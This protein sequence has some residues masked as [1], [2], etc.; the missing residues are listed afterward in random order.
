MRAKLPIIALTVFLGC[1]HLGLASPL[2]AARIDVVVD[3]GVDKAAEDQGRAAIN[4][5]ID[6]FQS[7]YGVALKRDLRIK[8]ACDKLNYKKAI[9]N[10][11]GM[12]EARA[13][14][15]SRNTSG[16]QSRG[17]LIVNLGELRGNFPQLFVLCHEMVHHY[18]GQI[19]G[20]RNGYL[21]WLSEGMADAVA[22][23]VLESVRFPG[24]FMGIIS[25]VRPNI[26]G[27]HAG[28][29]FLFIPIRGKPLSNDVATGA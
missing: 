17:A 9:Q 29:P 22:V 12:G 1:L 21:R 8:F 28:R 10:W 4:G 25:N 20:D 19:S 5:I 11:Y 27:I 24:P 13:N 18:Q 14:F 16:L 7:N 23:N 6:F 15:H 2:Q 26:Q 3:H